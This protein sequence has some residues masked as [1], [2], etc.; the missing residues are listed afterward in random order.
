VSP[1][2]LRSAHS[3]VIPRIFAAEMRGICSFSRRHPDRS[4]RFDGVV[5]GL[6]FDLSS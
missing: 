3:F 5:E 4:R 1:S 6:A 2:R